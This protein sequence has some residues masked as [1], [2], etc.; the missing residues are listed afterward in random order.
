MRTRFP[1][2]Q[3]RLAMQINTGAGTPVTIR[4]YDLAATTA[5]DEQTGEA[6]GGTGT[7]RSEL[8]KALVHFVSPAT[9]GFRVYNEL[10]I[11]DAFLDFE[12]GITFTGRDRLTFEV[13]G[14]QYTQKEMS[15][16][17][18]RSFDILYQGLSLATTI[19][20]TRRS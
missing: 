4:W 15:P 8:K 12:A 9:N 10:Q 5:S 1:F 20:V 7:A 2:I 18:A 19:L 3:A 14:N 16:E 17:L 6:L 11:G 13:G